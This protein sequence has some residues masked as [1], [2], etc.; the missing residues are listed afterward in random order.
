MR[1]HWIKILLIASGLFV[2]HSLDGQNLNQKIPNKTRILFLLDGSGS[3]LAQWGN[4]LRIHEAKRILSELVDSLKVNTQL[5]LALRVYGHQYDRRLRNCED[6]RLEYPFRA[7][8]HANIIKRLEEIKP[9][10]TT[11]IAYSLE[12]AASDFP[13]SN[14][15]RNI[16][17]II[18]DG[19]E[20]CQGDPC[21]VSLALQRKG[22]FLRPFIIG[23]GMPEKYKQQF[24][25]VGQYFDAND[26]EAF[27]NVLH[28]ALKQSLDKTTVSVEL[29][30]EKDQPTETDVNVTFYNNFTDIPEYE[31]V[32]Y[33]DQ[34][35]KPDSV[36][37][38]AVLSYDIVVNTIPP[39]IEKNI[40]LIGGEHNSIPIKTPQGYLQVHQPNHTEYKDL[41]KVLVS[42]N[43]K[44]NTLNVQNINTK[45]KYLVGE[46][47][48]EILT[49]PRIYKKVQVVQSENTI[50]N[51]P[52]PGLLNITS[53]TS[54]IGSIYSLNNS[55][56]E[57]WTL[58]LDKNK[59]KMNLAIQPGNYKLVFRAKN[60]QGSKFTQ[61]Q[62]FKIN[63]NTTTNINLVR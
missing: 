38:D 4:D 54:G 44:S 23:L 8:N 61:V 34:E 27:R 7:N 13:G 56:R 53:N 41:V 57:I 49:L 22:I 2:I 62:E 14:S 24:D 12:Q 36:V 21:E 33:R 63:S 6:T 18:T 26:T 15:H 40:T 47:Y 43:L 42:K 25:C 3:M 20:S 1:F 28:R 58:N 9:K 60:A 5:E 46:Y 17:I 52:A 55:I 59:S 48:L 30:D 11:P 51:I 37:V 31:F 35:G 16:I 10:G 45:D 39:V 29:L 19:I 32:H 50:I